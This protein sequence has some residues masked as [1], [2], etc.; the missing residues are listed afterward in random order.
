MSDFTPQTS[1]FTRCGVEDGSFNYFNLCVI[2]V[3][4]NNNLKNNNYD[5]CY[6]TEII[7][8]VVRNS[9]YAKCTLKILFKLKLHFLNLYIIHGYVLFASLKIFCNDTRGA[10]TV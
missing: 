5:G 4:Y 10:N 6:S 2:C 7:Q 1:R 8:Q 9:S 3:V